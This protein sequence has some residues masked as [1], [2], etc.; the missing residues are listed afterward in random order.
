MGRNVSMIVRVIVLSAVGL[1]MMASPAAADPPRPGDYTSEVTGVVPEVD[2]FDIRVFGGDAFLEL[3]ADPGV[4]IIV[5][6]Y[7][8][9]PYLRFRA[10]GGVDENRNS[11]AT[12]LNVDRYARADIPA[13]LSGV[14]VSGLDPDWQP[15]ADGRSYAW[16]DHRVHWMAPNAPPAVDRGGT[17]DW[18]GPVALLVDGVRVE[19]SGAISYHHTFSPAPWLAGA[20]VVAAAVWFVVRRFSGRWTAGLAAFAGAAATF[21]SWQELVDAP[22]GARGSAIP[23]GLAAVTTLIAVLAGLAPIRLR[24]VVLLASA[25]T[26][27]S[28]GIYRFGVLT[29]PILP[30]PLPFA[31]DRTITAAA[32]AVAVALGSTV[33]LQIS[34]AP[35]S[36]TDGA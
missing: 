14:D 6:G 17:F 5:L 22:T 32:L 28:W 11:T 9:E 33:F 27:G 24:P 16:H 20:L 1:V 26:L 23:V 7:E 8:D 15:I 18:N 21:A 29:N 19:V 34:T 10:D 36:H 30:T 12:Y 13:A 2:G 35:A 31:V 25:V 3:T 4:E